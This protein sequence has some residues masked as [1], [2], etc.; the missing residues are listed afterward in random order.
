MAAAVCAL[1]SIRPD[2]RPK[3]I[4]AVFATSVQLGAG[5]VY[6]GSATL[7]AMAEAQ[8]EARRRGSQERA[9]TKAKAKRAKAKAK[10]KSRG[11]RP[12]APGTDEPAVV[13][14]PDKTSR[15]RTAAAPPHTSACCARAASSHAA[16]A[17]SSVMTCA[18]VVER[19]A[20]D[21]PLGGTERQ[22]IELARVSQQL[23]RV[24]IVRL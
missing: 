18:D 17:P 15:S 22:D 6:V 4:H 1:A 11:R 16:A 24:N 23:R 9:R 12:P 20:S 8:A 21:P 13:G 19:M 10:K 3:R 2:F 7:V 14:E 5:A